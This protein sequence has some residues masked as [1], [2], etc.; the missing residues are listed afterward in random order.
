MGQVFALSL[1]A[2]YAYVAGPLD[3][4]ALAYMAAGAALGLAIFSTVSFALRRR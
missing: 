2:G 4:R 1:A 3:A